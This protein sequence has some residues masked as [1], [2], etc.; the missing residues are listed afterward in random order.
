MRISHVFVRSYNF[1]GYEAGET[2]RR[3]G[4][5]GIQR[6]TIVLV[7]SVYYSFIINCKNKIFL[8]YRMVLHCIVCNEMHFVIR[9][10]NFLSLIGQ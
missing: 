4:V 8:R 10:L 5:N 2:R 1:I 9:L 7:Y 6:C 3:E